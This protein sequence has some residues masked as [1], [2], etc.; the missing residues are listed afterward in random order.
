MPAPGDTEAG[1]EMRRIR[2]EMRASGWLGCR[3]GGRTERRDSSRR[4][5]H[6]LPR[7]ACQPVTKTVSDGRP[8]INIPPPGSGLFAL[9][10]SNTRCNQAMPSN[11]FVNSESTSQ[12]RG[13][14]RYAMTSR[15]L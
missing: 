2:A 13:L 15:S 9:S 6:R 12:K 7:V 1:T 5:I 8:A 3:Q 4:S 10:I 14:V 11:L